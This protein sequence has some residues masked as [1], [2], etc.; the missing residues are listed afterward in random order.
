MSA[1]VNIAE[2][3]PDI[4]TRILKEIGE[5]V[6]SNLNV[7]VPDLKQKSW[8]AYCE[9]SNWHE[10]ANIFE[11]MS[12]DELQALA[13]DIKANGQRNP[14]ILLADKVL[15]GR[16]RLL[17]CRIAGVQ[18]DFQSRNPEK[19]GSPVKWVLSQNLHRRHLT[20]SQRSMIALDAERLFAVEAK[21]R[22]GARTDIKAILPEGS[23]GQA[24]DQAAAACG[25]SPRYVQDAK[26]VAKSPTLADQVKAGKMSLA[27]AKL[28]QQL[29]K[30]QPEIAKQLQDGKLK[31]R[32]VAKARQAIIHAKDLKA[33]YS[34]K[35][36]YARISR[37]L[38]GAFSGVKERFEE[39]TRIKK[40]DW[41]PEAEDGLQN[42]I[43]SLNEVAERADEYASQFKMILKANKKAA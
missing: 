35:D 28:V 34:E 24:R 41:S 20:A 36:F 11:L 1:A 3:P 9:P 2:L 18:P 4:Q 37:G 5:P 25:V 27:T 12:A 23:K 26:S 17:A 7:A 13:N 8:Q 33:R 43:T 40:A 38:D 14:I 21:Q 32:D 6:S 39:L 10:A 16:N 42:L 19:L 15:D 31:P 29:E 22:Q 30:H